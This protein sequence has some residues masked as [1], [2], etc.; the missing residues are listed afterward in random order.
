MQSM[1]ISLPEPLKQFVD[2]QIAAGKYSSMSEYVR[3]LIR[4]DE[5]R[6]AQELLEEM[7][8]EG[9]AEESDEMTGEDWKQVRAEAMSLLDS[10]IGNPS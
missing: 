4:D 9:L 7:L 5:H 6:T 1:N 10:R 8:L 3:E 2:Q